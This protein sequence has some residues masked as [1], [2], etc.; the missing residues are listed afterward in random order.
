MK[1]RVAIKVFIRCTH[2]LV[3]ERRRSKSWPLISKWKYNKK[4]EE[5]FPWVEYDENFQGECLFKEQ[6]EHGS[7]S[8]STTGRRQ[9]RRWGHI[10]SPHVQ[11]LL[12]HTPHTV[13]WWC[14]HHLTWPLYSIWLAGLSCMPQ[15]IH[16]YMKCIATL[17]LT[18]FNQSLGIGLPCAVM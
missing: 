10:N 3:P 13:W 5:T 14:L 12:T 8:H 9:Q 18:S 7:L 1:N 6:E 15:Y 11:N 16:T 17:L 2:F 4:W